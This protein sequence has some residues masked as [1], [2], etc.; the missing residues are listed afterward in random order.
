[1]DNKISKCNH[2]GNL[3][4]QISRAGSTR[5]RSRRPCP[6]GPRGLF[7]LPHD[8]EL[9]QHARDARIAAG[10]DASALLQRFDRHRC[11]KPTRAGD[12]QPILEE[13]DL[14][15][16][17]FDPVVSVRQGIDEGL[18]PRE[19]RGLGRLTEE[20]VVQLG[21]RP[22]ERNDQLPRSFQDGV[23]IALDPRVVLHVALRADEHLGAMDPKDPDS[24][25]GMLD[26]R[27]IAGEEPDRAV[28]R[29]RRGCGRCANSS[30]DSS[31]PN[32]APTGATLGP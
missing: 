13:V 9:R 14:G 28:A 26:D 31:C 16:A 11:D 29:F 1:M 3:R 19:R 6:R 20:E 5:Q 23:K 25:V 30:P 24:E 18:L 4:I 21:R 15:A 22:D 8:P 2:T 32:G 17:T 27:W 12:L 7:L 10:V